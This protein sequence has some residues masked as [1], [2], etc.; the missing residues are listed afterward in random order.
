LLLT[1]TQCILALYSPLIVAFTPI[2]IVVSSLGYSINKFL[3]FL[4]G[5]KTNLGLEL[6]IS[7]VLFIYDLTYN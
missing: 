3:S 7:I 2:L 4:P 1:S 5:G 6:N